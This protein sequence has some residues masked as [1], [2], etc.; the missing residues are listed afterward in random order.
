VIGGLRRSSTDFAKWWDD[1]T[2]QERTNGTK[3]VRH[4]IGG[5][6]DL[7]YDVL[8]VQD[9]SEQRLLTLTPADDHAEAVLR[10]IVGRGSGLRVV[11]S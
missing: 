7:R 10:S 5:E 2:V 1:Q 6:L 4:P 3:R 8:A 9:G 11:G